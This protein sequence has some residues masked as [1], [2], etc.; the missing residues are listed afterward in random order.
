MRAWTGR[1]TYHSMQLLEYFPI[2]YAPTPLG[3]L[4]REKPG[5]RRCIRS[6]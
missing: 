3:L 2:F 6:I 4:A 5:S 1:K